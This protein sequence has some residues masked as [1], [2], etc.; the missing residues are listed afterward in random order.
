MQVLSGPD[1]AEWGRLL[2]DG[3]MY[4]LLAAAVWMGAKAASMALHATAGRMLGMWTSSKKAAPKAQHMALV[5]AQ[6][7]PPLVLGCIL[8]GLGMLE[9]K[10]PAHVDP[11]LAFG[12]IKQAVVEMLHR[13]E[14]LGALQKVSESWLDRK[15]PCTL[16]SVLQATD[17]TGT[18]AALADSLL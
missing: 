5:A 14:L 4:H 16:Q 1:T 8:T 10:I 3:F 2:L 15:E 13:M 9:D 12:A 6:L 7:L 17:A 11:F 18:C